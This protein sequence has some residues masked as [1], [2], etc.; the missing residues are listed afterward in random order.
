MTRAYT[1]YKR[2]SLEKLESMGEQIRKEEKAPDGI[3]LYPKNVRKKLDDI[4]W[5][6]TYHLGD[7][8]EA[9]K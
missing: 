1:L 2:Y 7:R 5:A 9:R 3:Y 8:K 6:I 4:A